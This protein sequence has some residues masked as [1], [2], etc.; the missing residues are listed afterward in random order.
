MMR[1]CHNKVYFQES[2]KVAFILEIFKS[3]FTNILNLYINN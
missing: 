3:C 2:A 1:F